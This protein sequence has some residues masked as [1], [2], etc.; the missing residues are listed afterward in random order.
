[1]VHQVA[2]IV[3]IKYSQP[4]FRLC[5][6]HNQV[7]ERLHKPEF[8]CANL[9]ATYDC[10]CGDAPVSTKT[11]VADPMDLERDISKDDITGVGLIMGGR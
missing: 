1:M 5:F 9:D 4:T 8:D 11:S 10:G 2:L 3:L 6:L 7:N